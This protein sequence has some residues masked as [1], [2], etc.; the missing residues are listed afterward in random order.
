MIN[1]SAY[2]AVEDDLTFWF[3]LVIPR[4]TFQSC[5]L[6]HVI[7]DPKPM[8]FSTHPTTIS[9][10]SNRLHPISLV[11]DTELHGNCPSADLYIAVPETRRS[12][13]KGEQV[14]LSN[15]ENTSIKV[16]YSIPITG[17]DRPLGF[18]EVK[19]PRFIDNRHMKV[20]RLS[21][22]HTG[23]LYPLGN[24]PGNHFC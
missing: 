3:L 11:L 10:L 9:G 24:T 19:A 8:M 20:V 23:R 22:L 6:C 21:A 16:R 2:L 12:V 15:P 13:E 1:T 5:C 7:S 4:E 18:Q 17:L 14:G